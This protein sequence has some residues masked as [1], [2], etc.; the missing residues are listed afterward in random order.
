[1]SALKWYQMRC[2]LQ[3]S[4]Q[5]AALLTVKTNAGFRSSNISTHTSI[6][7]I[8]AYSADTCYAREQLLFRKLIQHFTLSMQFPEAR[9]FRTLQLFAIGVA[10]EKFHG[11]PVPDH[12][13]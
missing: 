12:V 7:Y 4:Q 13:D 2:A 5:K 8:L 3:G 6:N 1:M 10:L 11:E 9:V